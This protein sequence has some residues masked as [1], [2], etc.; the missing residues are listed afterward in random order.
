MRKS[1]NIELLSKMLVIMGDKVNIK[2]R[3]LFLQKLVFVMQYRMTQRGH[4]KD[5]FRYT[6][7]QWNYGAWSPD[8]TKDF[9]TLIWPYDVDDKNIRLNGNV[10]FH[11]SN[12]LWDKYLQQS[13]DANI[14]YL[15]KL[16]PRELIRFST[17]IQESKAGIGDIILPSID[18]EF[19]D[20]FDYAYELNKDWWGSS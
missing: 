17:E 3:H 16:T 15:T 8:L 11:A 13:Y 2:H 12:S 18:F 1:Y 5:S 7:Y 9:K 6:F 19:K 4:A 14:N 20:W 10:E